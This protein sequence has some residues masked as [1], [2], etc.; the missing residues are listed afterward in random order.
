MNRHAR[1]LLLF[2]LSLPAL[3]LQAKES[4]VEQA[5]RC[6]KSTACPYFPEAYK[7]DRDFRD[8]FKDALKQAGIKRPRWVPDGVSGP[9]EPV[10]VGGAKMLFTNVCEPHN[11]G[12]HRLML[13]YRVDSK[14]MAGLYISDA[15]G[16]ISKTFFGNPSQAEQDVLKKDERN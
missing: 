2:A 11:C 15:D 5:L 14:S 3:P 10:V 4:P 1:L 16:K 6:T 9:V 13:L 7:R 12:D 8:A